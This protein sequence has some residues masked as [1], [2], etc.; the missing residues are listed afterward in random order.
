MSRSL[1]NLTSYVDTDNWFLYPYQVRP[2]AQTHMADG[3]AL[4]DLS[5]WHW[6]RRG[7]A[8]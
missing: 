7:L 4:F 5:V 6:Q 8:L 3:G 2:Q 1:V